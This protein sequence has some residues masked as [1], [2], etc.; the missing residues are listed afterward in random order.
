MKKGEPGGDLISFG[1][2]GRIGNL[3]AHDLYTKGLN[4]VIS[5]TSR[6]DEI[7]KE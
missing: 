3:I 1:G 6:V 7:I 2:R 4:S 5:D